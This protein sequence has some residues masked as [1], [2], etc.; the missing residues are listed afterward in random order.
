MK[1]HTDSN[2]RGWKDF[3]FREFSWRKEK[4][5]TVYWGMQRDLE[6]SDHMGQGGEWVLK[7]IFALPEGGDAFQI[8]TGVC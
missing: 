3:N 2:R 4:R 8:Q 1:A 6:I 7:P 5:K